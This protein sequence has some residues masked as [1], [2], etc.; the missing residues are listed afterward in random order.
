MCVAGK[1]LLK[2]KEGIVSDP[3]GALSDWV[4]DEVAFDPCNWFGVECSS[5]RR[6]VVL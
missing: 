4:D 1:A 5:D 2:M 6:V 3:F